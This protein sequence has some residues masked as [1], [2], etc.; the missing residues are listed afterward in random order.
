MCVCLSVCLSQ[1]K[2]C[3]ES[4]EAENA[5]LGHQLDDEKWC[6]SVCLSV[7]LSQLKSCVENL[8]AENA[9]LGHQ[10]DDEKRCVCVCLSVCHNSKAVLRVWR[11]RML[12]SATSWTMRNGVCVCLSGWR[13]TVCLS[14]CLSQLKSHVESLK[15][16]NANLGL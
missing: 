14:V 9:N 13:E 10:L 2:S 4:L 6:V 3:V 5:N 16:E 7:C 11:L 1:L 8:E 15:A 12:T